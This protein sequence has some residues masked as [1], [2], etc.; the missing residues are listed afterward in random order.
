[1][2][3]SV[4]ARWSARSIAGVLIAAGVV[5]SLGV[6]SAAGRDA[7]RDHSSPTP[8]T[9]IE[10][11]GCLATHHEA[12]DHE[13]NADAESDSHDAHSGWRA[14]A[15]LRRTRPTGGAAIG[16]QTIAVVVPRTTF[17]RVDAAGRVTEAATNTGCAPRT[18]DDVYLYHPDGTITLSP[19]I[20]VAARTWTGDFR[21]SGQ[22][23][24]QSA[25]G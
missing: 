11:S 10:S 9:L 3:T 21:H 8:T 24:P 15:R 4:V 2:R 22:F 13:A 18:G 14:D 25:L 7:R 1:M 12:D 16:T 5:V 17:L 20:D 6:A 19:T 23:Q